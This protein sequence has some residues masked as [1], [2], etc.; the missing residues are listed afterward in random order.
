MQVKLTRKTI[1][2]EE[3]RKQITADERD[4]LCSIAYY[5]LG[6]EREREESEAERKQKKRESYDRIE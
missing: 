4:F 6:R 1:R 5:Y 3:E 2:E